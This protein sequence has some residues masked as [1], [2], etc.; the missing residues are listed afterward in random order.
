MNE[1]SV[2]EKS[3]QAPVDQGWLKR[4][5]VDHEDRFSF[6]VFYVGAAVVLSLLISL[7]WLVVVV[8][9]HFLLEWVRHA[10][11]HP[12]RLRVFGESMW[13][14]KLDASLV[15]IALAL[16][17]YMPVVFGVLGLGTAA[18]VAG[19]SARFVV[20]Q[21]VIRGI[22]ISID[23]GLLVMRGVLKKFAGKKK[24][25]AAQGGSSQTEERAAS[26]RTATGDET[27]V[28]EPGTVGLASWRARWGVLDWASI[29]MALA[30]VGLIAVAPWITEHTLGSVMHEV[31]GDLHPWPI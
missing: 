24:K 27:P 26:T 5:I 4:W 10:Q 21:R 6:L 23:D 11:E 18:R 15:L 19:A 29:V 31:L 22:A 7:F 8:V 3:E 12:S 25:T 9:V 17:V 1:V 28:P 2:H 14:V 13:E 16:A 30:S 20:W